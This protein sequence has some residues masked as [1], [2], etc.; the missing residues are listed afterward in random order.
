MK[1]K[2]KNTIWNDHRAPIPN[3]FVYERDKLL[4]KA[5]DDC[6]KI[7]RDKI[8]KCQRKNYQV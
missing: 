6:D 7:F 3:E 8:K 4:E 2:K 5:E 1:K